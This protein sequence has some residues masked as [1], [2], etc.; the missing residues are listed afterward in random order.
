MWNIN[1]Y[2]SAAPKPWI[3]RVK[4][5]I[6]YYSKDKDVILSPFHKDTVKWHPWAECKNALD[7]AEIAEAFIP[8]THNEHDN[9]WRQAS[10][11]FFPVFY[12]NSMT[13][14]KARSS[15]NGYFLSH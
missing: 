10:R 7:F 12:K 5:A 11:T 2:D 8:H 14:R 13:H 1:L 9:Y 4:K 15:S 3:E 6:R